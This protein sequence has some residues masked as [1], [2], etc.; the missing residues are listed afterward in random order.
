MKAKKAKEEVKKARGLDY[1]VLLE[2]MITE[3]AAMIGGADH[4]GVVFKVARKASKDQIREAVENIYSV[5]VESIR[6]A[7]YL[8]KPKRSGRSAGRRAAYKKAFIRLKPGFAIE[9]IEGV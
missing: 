5:Q 8:G 2:P 1:T 6:T 3:K 4:T 9:L 7:N